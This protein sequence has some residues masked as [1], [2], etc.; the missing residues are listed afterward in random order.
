MDTISPAYKKNNGTTQAM[1]KSSTRTHLLTCRKALS[2]QQRAAKS[3]AIHTRIT[4]LP[5]WDT[6]RTLLLYLPVNGEVDTWALF[7]WAQEKGCRIVLPCCRKNEPGCMDFFTVMNKEE[8]IPGM[9]NIPEPDRDQCALMEDPDPE[10]VIL[11]GV[12]FDR[13][14]Y[15]L[16]Y[17][18]GYYDRFLA[19]HPMPSALIVGLGFSC[20]IM[21]A[22]PHDPWDKKV[23]VVVTEKEMIWIEKKVSAPYTVRSV[24]K[25][26][27]R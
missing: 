21:D 13:Q 1:N 23:D 18:G 25:R 10:V 14:G 8:L 7:D 9:Y 11:P 5:V 22:L 27:C 12:G 15:R 6:A 17:G 26:R 4:S 24:Q 16:G 19:R 3:K 20:Q 2:P